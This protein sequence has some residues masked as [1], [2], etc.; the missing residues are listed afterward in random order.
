MMCV[1]VYL[2]VAVFSVCQAQSQP[3]P[4]Q[5]DAS[6][7]TAIM[8]GA[9]RLQAAPDAEAP[10][11]TLL[12]CVVD[13]L[14]HAVKYTCEQTYEA[15]ANAAKKARKIELCLDAIKVHDLQGCQQ[16]PDMGPGKDGEGICEDF[17]SK[18]RSPVQTAYKAI[19]MSSCGCG[20][21]TTWTSPPQ[22]LFDCS[23]DMGI[24]VLLGG[25]EHFKQT[26]AGGGPAA[27]EKCFEIMALNN[28]AKCR[29]S[30]AFLAEDCDAFKIV[31]QDMLN[32][33]KAVSKVC[34]VADAGEPAL[35]QARNSG[36]LPQAMNAA[37]TRNSGAPATA[38][39]SPGTSG[40]KVGAGAVSGTLLTPLTIVGVFEAIFAIML[41]HSYNSLNTK[42]NRIALLDFGSDA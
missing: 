25:C 6:V 21:P 14:V 5:T 28:D 10:P 30:S 13:K 18:V 31:K 15:E 35:Q 11:P 2:L 17:E 7:K 38:N 42:R 8:N 36:A 19:K 33:W 22:Y 12:S 39:T 37:T 3:P 4:Q 27:Y 32:K 20:N 41:L 1:K 29:A 26:G 16:N 9:A 34:Q 23:T 40:V 24:S